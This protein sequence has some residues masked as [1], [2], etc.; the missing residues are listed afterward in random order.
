MELPLNDYVR[1][2]GLQPFGLKTSPRSELSGLSCQL[3]VD[4]N[5]VGDIPGSAVSA[6][7]RLQAIE[8][9]LQ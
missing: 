4:A 8:A 3:V 7:L 9:P 6:V 2:L 1:L 5:T